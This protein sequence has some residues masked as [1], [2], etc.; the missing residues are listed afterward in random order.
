MSSFAV[1]VFGADRERV[2]VSTQYLRAV[3]VTNLSLPSGPTSGEL[4]GHY[5]TQLIRSSI[6][7][8]RPTR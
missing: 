5:C 3:P 2:V 8:V 4:S 6:Q 1:D 7:N